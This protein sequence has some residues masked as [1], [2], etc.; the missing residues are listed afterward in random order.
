MVS[1]DADVVSSG[2]IFKTW[3]PATYFGLGEQSRLVEQK[4][5]KLLI[6][7][8]ILNMHRCKQICCYSDWSVMFRNSDNRGLWKLLAWYKYT[9]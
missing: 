3:G 5:N 9:V 2:K 7:S 4:N 1:G 8:C 6:Y